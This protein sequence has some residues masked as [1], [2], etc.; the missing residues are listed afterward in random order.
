MPTRRYSKFLPP[1]LSMSELV[2][3]KLDND[4]TDLLIDKWLERPHCPDAYYDWFQRVRERRHA[5]NANICKEQI[6]LWNRGVFVPENIFTRTVDTGRLIPLDRTWVTHVYHHQSM[7]RLNM[8]PVI[9]SM[10]PELMLLR[11][12]HDRG[13]DEIY[14]IVTDLKRQEMDQVT[15][16]FKYVCRNIANGPC[17]PSV[18]QRI[19]HDHMNLT[20]ILDRNRRTPCFPQIDL[21]L[22]AILFEKRPPFVI[23][24][25]HQTMS[26]S[27]ILFANSL[28]VP[29]KDV[30]FDFPSGCPNPGCTD[31]C[32]ELIRFPKKGLEIAAVLCDKRKVRYRYGRRAKPRELCNWI[33]CQICFDEAVSSAHMQEGGSEGSVAGSSE[34]SEGSVYEARFA[35]LICSRCKLVKY[36]SP[37]HQK[38]DWEEHRRVC[39]KPSPVP[40]PEA[41]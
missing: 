26:Y 20:H 16:Y 6:L 36:C 14:V 21:T 34:G 22:R 3:Q 15:E 25:S 23:L 9:F 10:L 32:C 5:A 27:Q 19:N 18:E 11:G 2:C 28:F 1:S 40:E 31:N 7:S 4:A 24:F 38:L 41:E 35:G 17:K 33:D 13:C 30:Y 29:S 12:M 37:D 8:M 39:V